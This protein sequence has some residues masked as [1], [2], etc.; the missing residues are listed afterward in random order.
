MLF[1]SI[2]VSGPAQAVISGP[3]APSFWTMEVIIGIAMPL[4]ILFSS[5]F[6]SR[7]KIVLAASLTM[8]GLLFSRIGF[9]YSGLVFPLPIVPKGC[10]FFESLNMYSATWS[11]WSLVFGAMG[12][13]YL[14]FSLAEDKLKL[15]IGDSYGQQY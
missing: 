4:I 1:R 5:R 15:N 2:L 13:I 7:G 8:V 10:T 9:V 14:A 11:E 12:F 6:M 3:L